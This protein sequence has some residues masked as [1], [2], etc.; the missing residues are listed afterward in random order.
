MRDRD[1]IASLM[2]AGLTAGAT[3][4][5]VLALIARYQEL[6]STGLSS[7]VVYVASLVGM[8]C[9]GV[10]GGR[11]LAL[12]KPSVIGVGAPVLCCAAACA[13]Y[14]VGPGSGDIFAAGFVSFVTALEYPN[15]NSTVAVLTSPRARSPAFSA[16]Q[17]AN[18]LI[19]ALAPLLGAALIW[20]FGAEEAML[21]ITAVYA[22][23]ILPWLWI[24]SMPPHAQK[25]RMKSSPYKLL[26][27][28]SGLRG[29]TISRLLNNLIYVGILVA[30]P[31]LI[32]QG[33]Q[34]HEEFVWLLAASLAVIRLGNMLAGIVGAILLAKRPQL[35]VQI[36]YAATLLGVPAAI[37]LTL[38][39]LPVSVLFWGFIAGVGHY[40]CRV[41]GM[42]LGPSV[43]SG[44]RLAEVILAGDTVVRL[45]AA[46]YGYCLLMALGYLDGSGL[47]LAIAALLALPAPFFLREAVNAYLEQVEAS[48]HKGNGAR[49][50]HNSKATL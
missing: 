17:S 21:A 9:M 24:P 26:F 48:S 13:T 30:L 23:S 37:A 16:L 44:D 10:L 36:T 2:L 42:I 46:T 29:L 39:S 11:I 20:A 45:Y 38:V 3:E 50:V 41:S 7:S 47:P 25:H 28:Q 31:V 18:T 5:F 14:I 22:L 27:T 35:I 33:A 19:V 1:L 49:D 34:N 32:S 6:D 8:A 43:T 4:M 40:S 15:V 12:A